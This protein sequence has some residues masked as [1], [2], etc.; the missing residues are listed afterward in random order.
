M[1]YDTGDAGNTGIAGVSP[2]SIKECLSTYSQLCNVYNNGKTQ[3]AAS[4]QL[5]S[6]GFGVVGLN[7]GA[8]GTAGAS[9]TYPNKSDWETQA[10]SQS[11]LC[12]SLGQ[13]LTV[14]PT[15]SSNS[16]VMACWRLLLYCSESWRSSSSALSVAVCMATMRAA[17]SLA[18]LSSRAVYTMR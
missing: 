14:P 15:M 2:A 1:S 4:P 17:C 18:L 13:E 16:L 8:A 6:V 9:P 10:G 11:S 12:V 5:L 3:Q 7:T